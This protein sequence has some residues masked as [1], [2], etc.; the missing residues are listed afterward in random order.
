MTSIDA[1]DPTQQNVN[2]VETLRRPKV[3][4]ASGVKSRVLYMDVLRIVA[5]F[6]VVLIH[7]SAVYL[8]SFGDIHT[9]GWYV[10]NILDSG[11][12][13]CVPIFLMISGAFI[14]GYK[15]RYST[16]QF[17]QKRFTK[18][19]IPFVIWTVIYIAWQMI[20]GIAKVTNRHYILDHTIFGPAIYHMWFF[21]TILGLYLVTPILAVFANKANK[22]TLIF[23]A[24]VCIVQNMAYPLI[25]LYTGL[26][27]YFNIPLT[28]QYVDYFLLGWI[29]KD[30]EF[31]NPTKW[32][33]Y[34]LGVAGIAVT[35]IENYRLSVREHKL[36]FFFLN[37][38]NFATLFTALAV[39]TLVKSIPW[40]KVLSGKM[41][42]KILSLL[43]NASLGIYLIHVMILYYFT[44]IFF[45]PGNSISTVLLMAL[46]GAFIV[47]AVSAV[48]VMALQKI[49]FVKYLVP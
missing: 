22:M 40:D 6:F 49:P 32:L 43:A 26:H 13:W 48:I 15:E 33:L 25:V 10:A 2:L 38:E 12:R 11:S 24:G 16:R 29:L 41:P 20:T 31:K 37:Y 4:I 1:L 17:F 8:T 19:L 27:P 23:L 28:T 39:Y 3:L 21:Y 35:I 36:D 7:S 42:L 18:V 14:L 30:V 44:Q 46:G 9:K 34:A 5:S 47:F 45:I